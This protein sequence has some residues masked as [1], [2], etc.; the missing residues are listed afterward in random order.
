LKIMCLAIYQTKK[1]K[2]NRRKFGTLMTWNF[3]VKHRKFK[4]IT[5]G[6]ACGRTG[7]EGIHR[8]DY[9]CSSANLFWFYVGSE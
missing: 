8:A 6:L 1:N 3:V 5:M 2:V 7:K 9:L 4:K